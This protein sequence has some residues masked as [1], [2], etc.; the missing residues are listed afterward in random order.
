MKL[1]FRLLP[2][3]PCSR[4][5]KTRGIRS[6]SSAPHQ[7]RVSP[8][9]APLLSSTDIQSRVNS[10]LKSPSN[11]HTHTLSRNSRG[12]W[13]QTRIGCMASRFQHC[14]F[15][16]FTANKTRPQFHNIS[17]QFYTW[18]YYECFS[19]M[20]IYLRAE[21]KTNGDGEAIDILGGHRGNAASLQTET[22]SSTN[23]IAP[24]K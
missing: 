12:K 21:Q 13:N 8:A 7:P 9:S 16:L 4:K 22:R 23:H 1:P 10:V 5:Q 18:L 6:P 14:R 24:L 20:N 11:H 3:A 19:F 2:P 15:D 17:I